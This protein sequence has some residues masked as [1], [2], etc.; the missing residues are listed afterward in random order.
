MEVAMQIT[1]HV[2]A[3]KVRFQAVT[4][5]GVM[6]RTVYVYLVAGDKYSCLIDTGV[7]S[8]LSDVLGFIT[9]AGKKP[10][11]IGEI[12]ITHAHTDHIGSLKSLKQRLGCPAA[13][14]VLSSRW[15]EDVDAQFRERPVPGFYDVVEGSAK[16]E[17]NLADR[18]IIQLGASTLITYAAPGHERGQ[19]AFFH[20]QDGVL[21]TADCIPVIGELPIYDDLSAEISSVRRLSEVDG[22]KVLLMSW[23]D[24]HTGDVDIRRVFSN[25]LAYIRKIH[26]LTLEGIVRYRE[27]DVQAVAKYVHSALGLHPSSFLPLF[28]DTVKAHIREKDLLLDI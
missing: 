8:S 28:V 14:S 10:D 7:Y 27:T 13:A 2:H 24:P 6:E 1:E 11:D 22:V 16:I 5:A 9:D 4:Q 18:D 12:L 17:R 23:D 19:L 25:A 15:I 21:F 3:K 26:G 20:E